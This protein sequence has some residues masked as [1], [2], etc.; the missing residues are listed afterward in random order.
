MWA[1]FDWFND[2]TSIPKVIGVSRSALTPAP[3]F[4]GVYT[5]RGRSAQGWPLP[6]QGEGGKS[7][8]LVDER[9]GG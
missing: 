1:L 2:G 7:P 4:D 5:E 9:A 8:R 6:R 3:P